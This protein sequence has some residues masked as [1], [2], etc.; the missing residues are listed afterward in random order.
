MALAI[1]PAHIVNFN[2]EAR[3]TLEPSTYTEQWIFKGILK[4]KDLFIYFMYMSTLW[5]YR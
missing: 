1:G 2:P 4:K 3:V 5:L